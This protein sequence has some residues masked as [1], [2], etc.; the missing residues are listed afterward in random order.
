MARGH[1]SHH[2]K[3]LAPYLQSGVQ[4]WEA[5]R[6]SEGLAY[7]YADRVDDLVLTGRLFVAARSLPRDEIRQNYDVLS[8]RRHGEWIRLPAEFGS[9]MTEPAHALPPPHVERERSSI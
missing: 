7:L 3:R 5:V 4:P 1:G 8:A 9:G 2:L 6:A